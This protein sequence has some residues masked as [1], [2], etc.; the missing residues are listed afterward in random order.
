MSK[1]SAQVIDFEA[2]VQDL[3]LLRKSLDALQ[4]TDA[5]FRQMV[6][7]AQEGIWIL[8]RDGR[9]NYVNRQMAHLL[10]YSE[11][12]M[13]GRF[14]YEFMDPDAV[15][16]AAR[17]TEFEGERERHDLR[18]R[19]KSGAPVWTICSTSPFRDSRGETVGALG[20]FTD[21][22]SRKQTEE[23]LAHSE[24]LSR[25][26]IDSL[27]ARI[28]VLDR[29][30]MIIA[31][32]HGWEAFARANGDPELTRTG[33]GVNY[34]AVLSG[35]IG[36]ASALG[37][38]DALTG[39]QRV[40]KGSLK[41]FAQ[42]Y[43][44][45]GPQGRHWFELRATPIHTSAG[46]AVVAH[47]DVTR[48]KKAEEALKASRDFLEMKVRERTAR[49]DQA[50]EH[51]KAEIKVRQYTEERLKEA[52]ESLNLAGLRLK[53][54]IEG[55]PD[56]I[57]AV[58][59]E[60]CL[61]AFNRAYQHE[62]R[63]IFGVDIQLGSSLLESVSHVP[64]DR[65]ASQSL[66]ARALAG[67]EFTVTA[68]LG[69]EVRQR[70]HYEITFSPI[71]GDDGH[72]VGASHIVRDVSARKIA[73]AQLAELLARFAGAFDHAPIGMA[74]VSTVGALTKVNQALS[75]IVGFSEQD[76]LSTNL[77]DLVYPEDMQSARAEIGRLIDGDV[78]NICLEVRCLH[79][80][81]TLIWTQI[82]ASAVN[83]ELGAPR[84]FITQIQ[85][86]SQSKVAERLLRDQASFDSLTKLPN[87]SLFYDRLN[88][89]V[90]NAE[91]AGKRFS[92][93]F[94]D[95]DNFKTINDT[96][97][98]DMGDRLLVSVAGRL[99]ECVRRNDTIARLGGDEFTVLLED[100]SSP[101][102]IVRTAERI[103]GALAKPVSFD[104]LGVFVSASIGIAV[105]PDDGKDAAALLKCADLAMYRAKEQGKSNYQF[106]TSELHHR[107]AER[108]RMEACLRQA[109]ERK[110]LTL[111]WLP[112]VNLFSGAV[113]GVEA[114]ARWN[115]PELG[116]VPPER[117]IALAEEAGLIGALDAWVV[118]QAIGKLAQWRD[119]SNR[120]VCVSVNI[121]GRELR[122]M[123][124]AEKLRA[125]LQ[126][127][128]VEASR[129]EIDIPEAATLDDGAQI[130]RALNELKAIGVRIAL[131]DFGSGVAPL[132]VLERLPVDRVKLD[133]ARV[134]AIGQADGSERLAGALLSAAKSL[135]VKVIAEGVERAGQVEWLRVHGCEEAQGFY[136]GM[137]S[138]EP[139]LAIT[140]KR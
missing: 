31:A 20:M 33:C 114:L 101:D 96:M 30:G 93:M 111:H 82:S 105:Y 139:I 95:L 11:D 75:R 74:L 130:A 6:E 94:V 80:N 104:D 117:F 126:R 138:T 136:F 26:I 35:A 12:E 106:F 77:A 2:V 59:R 66:W 137:P 29:S 53:G 43:F 92:L 14:M 116:E 27:S 57:A 48:R 16:E 72:I 51:L 124:F 10:G 87:R 133:R 123:G 25:S 135:G 32:N 90:L 28:A 128:G 76:L 91:R 7:T 52:V 50:N 21:I 65:D 61:T 47:I 8:D 24:A 38:A 99:R 63:K 64:K 102:L 5:S 107:S 18:L 100:V 85:D 69:D 127:Y 132:A 70:N 73:E 113:V 78:V 67:E 129:L 68:E 1:S 122:Q 15:T 4:T 55:T 88:R 17:A 56:L 79:K 98:H 84:Y 42:E 81:G 46:G 62:F 36:G 71:R 97:G 45:D 121:S 60:M 83:D 44:A 109:L 134:A 131:D 19:H 108:M 37:I 89:C 34:I 3:A 86:V 112:V 125:T 39:L 120:Y 41:E 23:K 115:H 49:L 119:S 118:E 140:T 103:V 110:E 9:T 40:L 58:D 22:S 54:I 13:R